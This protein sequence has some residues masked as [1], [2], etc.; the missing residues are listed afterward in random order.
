MWV[1]AGYPVLLAAI[2][3]LWR[4]LQSS[5]AARFRMAEER[6]RSYEELKKLLVKG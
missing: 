6:Q 5:Q 4:A 1:A 3:V 2:G